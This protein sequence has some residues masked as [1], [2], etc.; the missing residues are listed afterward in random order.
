M[1]DIH[2]SETARTDDEPAE[3]PETLTREQLHDLVWREPMLRIGERY[4]VAALSSLRRM[5]GAPGRRCQF[6]LANSPARTSVGRAGLRL[7]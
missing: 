3:A 5:G 7:P 1:T 2:Q 4:R 6:R